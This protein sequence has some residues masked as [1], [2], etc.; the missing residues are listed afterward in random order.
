M[1]GPFQSIWVAHMA[2]T[3][4]NTHGTYGG[5]IGFAV[6]NGRL[7]ELCS[8]FV[9]LRQ[10]RWR[11]PEKWNQAMGVERIP[12]PSRP[13]RASTIPSLIWVIRNA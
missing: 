3:G 11:N 13:P 4:G 10:S 2:L 12:A 6:V 9:A 5:W 8:V 1:V 7:L